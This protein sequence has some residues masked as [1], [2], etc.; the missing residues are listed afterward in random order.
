MVQLNERLSAAH[1]GAWTMLSDLGRRAFLPL[2]IPQQAAQA[3]HVDRRATIGEITDGGGEP[4]TIPSL[5][6]HFATL[7]PRQALLY[8][9]QYGF[10]ELRSAWR[11]QI[12]EPGT[13]VSMPVVTSGI[14][15]ALSI[16]AE[17]FTGPKVPL[18]VG[19]PYWDNYELI[20]SLKTGCPIVTYPFFG[21]DGRFNVSAL[22]AAV[23][24]VNGPACILL[25]F[26]SNPTGYSPYPDEVDALAT[27]LADLPHPVAVVCDDAYNGLYFEPDSYGRSL[28]G[29]LARAIDPARGVVCKVDGATKEL[30]FFGGRVGFVTFSAEG[31]AADALEEKAATLIRAAISTVSAPSQAA[32]LDALRSPT[33]AQERAAVHDVLASRYAVLRAALDAHG[34]EAWPYNSGCFALL[35][36]P[37]HLECEATRQRLIREHS[38]GVIAV[39][40]VNALRVAFCSI[41]AEDIPDLVARIARGIR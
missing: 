12:A 33:L 30:V 15:H 8:P 9:P 41:E 16:C 20:F 5:S 27:A 1:P 6:R 38:V 34:L 35:K 21:E 2:G 28:Y 32:V 3:R 14:T 18:V 31:P 11:D 36:L 13:P 26:P 19:V 4:L 40:Q 17:L 25:N 37:R 22:V 7:D 29:A 10:S 23:R 24:T 39:P